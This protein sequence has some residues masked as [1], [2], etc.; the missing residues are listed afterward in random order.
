MPCKTQL[1]LA[2]ALMTV[3]N[4]HGWSDRIWGCLACLGLGCTFVGSTISTSSQNSTCLLESL[5]L[6]G[7]ELEVIAVKIGGSSLTDKA[8]K[9]TINPE[10]L[11]WFSQTVADSIHEGYTYKSTD[12]SKQ[13]DTRSRK[14][15]Y[16]IVHGAGKVGLTYLQWQY[17]L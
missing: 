11:E 8:S 14:R 13:G 7:E 4:V 10:A 6:D 17:I 15:A 3:S 5:T 12:S 16:V 1:L 2:A 9:E